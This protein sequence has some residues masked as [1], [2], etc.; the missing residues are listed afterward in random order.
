M[1]VCPVCGD[2]FNQCDCGVETIDGP[3]DM[4]A[5]RAQVE[6]SIYRPTEH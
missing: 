5:F 6:K 1:T 3:P 2:D 4:D